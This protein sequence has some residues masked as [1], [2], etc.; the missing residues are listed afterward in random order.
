L[1]KNNNV[2]L[3]NTFKYNSNIPID[4]SIQIQFSKDRR[5]WYNSNGIKDGIDTI[6]SGSDSIKLSS[7]NWNESYFYLRFNFQS[8]NNATPILK[9]YSIFY[10]KYYS[11]GFFISEPFKSNESAIWKSYNLSVKKPKGTEI[12]LQ[13]RSGE[14]QNELYSNDFVGPH[15]IKSTFY[16]TTNFKIWS[17]HDN[18][19]WFQYKIILTTTNESI[20]PIISKFKIYYN[21][22]PKITNYINDSLKGDITDFLNFSITYIDLDNDIPTYVRINIDGNNYSMGESDKS[23]LN[24]K[25][26]KN[27]KFSIKLKAGN[28]TFKYFISD[29]TFQISSNTQKIIIEKGPLF[30]I[31]VKPSNINLSINNSQLFS[32]LGYDFDNN[33]ILIQPNWEINGGGIIDKNGIF[34]P[35]KPGTWIIYA[36]YSGISGNTSIYIYDT[37]TIDIDEDHMPDVWEQKYGLNATNSFDAEFD[38]D[39]DYL[40][41]YAEY[42]NGT[43][44]FSFDTDGDAFSDRIEIE[45]DT[46]PLNR[47]DFPEID[48]P[49]LN[50][51][52]NN[53]EYIFFIIIGI[54]IIIILIIIGFQINK[55][56]K[57]KENEEDNKE[58]Y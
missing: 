42:L 29:G 8:K 55:R 28:H 50:E 32:A 9:E 16:Y 27:Y 13:F 23:D 4:S 1:L 35:D 17:G 2:V 47:E 46:D 38:F 19:K 26:G 21:Q 15:G 53:N 44:P 34:S 33:S 14:S 12:K 52:N 20:T 51:K 3:I 45:M 31:E 22:I 10:E 57:K 49:N 25:N 18:E 54:I 39:Y 43:N 58:K 24:Y 41:N 40:I 11:N 36:N 37:N 56:L 48:D 5:Y 6:I 30:R 7:L